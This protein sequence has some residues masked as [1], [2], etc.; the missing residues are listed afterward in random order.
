MITQTSSRISTTSLATSR[1]WS[2]AGY[3]PVTGRDGPHTIGL[4]LGNG[5]RI[6]SSEL[7]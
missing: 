3:D 2:S 4:R 5:D 6:D 1:G 7:R